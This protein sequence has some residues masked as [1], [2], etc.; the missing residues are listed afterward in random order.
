[1]AMPDGINLI[2]VAAAGHA[3]DDGGTGPG[4]GRLNVVAVPSRSEEVFARGLTALIEGLKSTLTTGGTA[5]GAR[6]QPEA[7]SRA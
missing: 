2:S 3:A 5:P 1:M 7:E 6:R 4:V